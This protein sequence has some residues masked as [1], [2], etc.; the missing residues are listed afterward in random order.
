MK[1][2]KI[3]IISGPSGSGKDT[4]IRG[5]LKKFP[6]LVM[7]KSYTTRAKRKSDEVGNRH[8]V[9]KIKF[10]QMIKNNEFLEYKKFC[11]NLYG[12]TKKDIVVPLKRGKNLIMEVDVKGTLDYQNIFGGRVVAIFVKYQNPQQLVKRIKKTRPEISQRDL[13]NRLKIMAEELK[14]EKYYNHSVINPEGHPEKAIDK[15]SKI[16]SVYTS[17]V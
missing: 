3:F 15:V 11:G 13:A 12:R 16:I 9:N 10:G 6:D 17:G 14:Y 1:E 4:V 8:F 2:P 5:I 7:I